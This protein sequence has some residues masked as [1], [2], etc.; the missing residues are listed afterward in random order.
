[1]SDKNVKLL[2]GGAVGVGQVVRVRVGFQSRSEAVQ[3]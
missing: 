2:V 3:L 1:M